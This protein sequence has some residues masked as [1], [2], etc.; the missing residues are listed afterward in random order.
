MDQGG[1]PV[2]EAL[3]GVPLL[4]YGPFVT[5]LFRLSGQKAWPGDNR[6]GLPFRI[7]RDPGTLSGS[8]SWTGNFPGPWS[9]SMLRE[10]PG[11]DDV[12]LR[13]EYSSMARVTGTVKWFND[14]K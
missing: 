5:S 10:R 14:A 11:I 9:L 7:L 2:V 8:F 3:T 4:T 13:M 12:P 6:A 1:A